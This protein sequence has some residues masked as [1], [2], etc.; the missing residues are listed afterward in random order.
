MRKTTWMMTGWMLLFSA[1]IVF[2]KPNQGDIDYAPSEVSSGQQVYASLP[3][4]QAGINV[5]AGNLGDY[6]S[7]FKNNFRNQSWSNIHILFRC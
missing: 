6:E 4:K 5:V 2:A 3:I 7:D 1:T